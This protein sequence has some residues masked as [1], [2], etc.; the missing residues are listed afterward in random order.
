MLEYKAAWYGRT[1]LKVDRQFPSSQLCSDCG[2]RNKEV[3]NPEPTY[4]SE[5]VRIVH[6]NRYLNAAIN[7]FQE[8]LRF[9]AVG[10]TVYAWSISFQKRGL[11]E[12]PLPLGMESVNASFS[13]TGKTV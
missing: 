1:I 13:F 11:P 6:H 3:K 5:Y 12:N 7:I 4:G 9:I 2:K 8:G 10:H